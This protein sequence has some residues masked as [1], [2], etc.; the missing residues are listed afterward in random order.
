MIGTTTFPMHEGA[1]GSPEDAEMV[2][3]GFG[4]VMRRD[5]FAS[6][7]CILTHWKP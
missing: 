7:L 5:S 3:E 4:I 6:L 1:M 2:T